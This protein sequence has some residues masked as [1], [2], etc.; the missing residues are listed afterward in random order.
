MAR[1][2]V[3]HPTFMAVTAFAD[4]LRFGQL[5][6]AGGSFDQPAGLMADMRTVAGAYH[7]EMEKREN[8]ESKRA[9]RK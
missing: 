2:K 8:R 4:H 3:P 1:G 6:Y 7:A 5:P 9:R